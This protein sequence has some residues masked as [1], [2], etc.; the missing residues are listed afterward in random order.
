M[1]NKGVFKRRWIMGEK[2]FSL[3]FAVG[4][5]VCGV[6]LFLNTIRAE[7]KGY[8]AK[9][10]LAQAKELAK[11]WQADAV[12]TQVSALQVGENG[13]LIPNSPFSMWQY[14]FY[15][16]KAKKWYNVTAGAAG[17][18]GFEGSGPMNAITIDFVDSD[19]VLE[20]VKK[21]GFKASGNIGMYL[22]YASDKNMKWGLYWY[23]IDDKDPAYARFYVDPRTGKF[24][25]K[26]GGM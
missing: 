17:V 5:V 23:V 26:S 9:A 3:L 7:E 1:S 22:A 6:S 4:L 12:L 19:R 25:G 18:Q 15:S 13:R 16:Q 14:F 10:S 8:T 11:K 24:L 20:E 2:V 21:N